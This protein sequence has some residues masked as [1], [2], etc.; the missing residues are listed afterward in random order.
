MLI[1]PWPSQ[2]PMAAKG[3]RPRA[4]PRHVPKGK[5]APSIHRGSSERQRAL[6]E[7]C[8][9]SILSLRAG[10]ICEMGHQGAHGA[11]R[12]VQ[13]AYRLPDTLSQY[14]DIMR[15]S[16]IYILSQR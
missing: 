12:F 10:V 8:R 1:M 5:R 13:M 3:N 2:V 9:L 16:W 7:C 14:L 4:T 6:G 15:E 11:D